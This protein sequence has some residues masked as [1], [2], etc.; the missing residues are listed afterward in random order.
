[1]KPK[2]VIP[3]PCDENWNSMTPDEKGRF[4]AVCQ[5]SVYDFTQIGEREIVKIIRSERSGVCGR[6]NNSTVL[7]KNKFQKIAYQFQEYLV[8]RRSN[9][10]FMGFASF[11]LFITGCKSNDK[12]VTT[13]IVLVD[14][15]E[16]DNTNYSIGEAKIQDNDSSTHYLKNLDSIKVVKEPTKQQEVE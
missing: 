7:P 2:I 4:C 15:K 8:N 1:M 3:K 14:V 11:L 16:M 12:C 10:L 9:Q 6:F 13:G 5:K